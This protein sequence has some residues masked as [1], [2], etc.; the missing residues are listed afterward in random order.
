M[1]AQSWGTWSK[2]M[3]A[4][5]EDTARRV[6]I[7]S[8][9]SLFT[10]TVCE[11]YARPMDDDVLWPYIIPF[12]CREK[13][14]VC[15][16][17]RPN[18]ERLVL[19]RLHRLSLNSSAGVPRIVVHGSCSSPTPLFWVSSEIIRGDCTKSFYPTSLCIFIITVSAAGCVCAIQC[20][21]VEQPSYRW[22]PDEGQF[23]DA[24]KANDH[25]IIH[26]TDDFS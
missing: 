19:V 16:A 4:T 8:K 20:T 25:N 23:P 2:A 10:A 11:K 7:D 17:A 18:K 26:C 1:R 5:I 13:H 3:P 15:G 9:I 24:T 21:G 6:M 12:A 22:D 14:S